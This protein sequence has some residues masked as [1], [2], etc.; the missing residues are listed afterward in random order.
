MANPADSLRQQQVRDTIV[1]RP[2]L[3]NEIADW[4]AARHSPMLVITGR[5][6]MG[7]TV[8]CNQ[9]AHASTKIT[10][11]PLSNT[12]LASYQCDH[13]SVHTHNPF[14]FVD[15]LV[16]QASASR[17]FRT[18]AASLAQETINAS[19]LNIH[20]EA[21]V[22][23]NW[24]TAVGVFIENL[25]V[26][27]A[28]RSLHARFLEP[29]LRAKFPVAP[30]ILI[31]G[32]DESSYWTG[33]DSI[34]RLV[35]SGAF[36]D[37][38]IRLVVTTRAHSGTRTLPEDSLVIDL[39]SRLQESIRDVA[40]FI[41]QRESS[42]EEVSSQVYSTAIATQSGGNFLCA[43]FLMN[44]GG[45]FGGEGQSSS[46]QADLFRV[47]EHLL[48]P[49]VE[50]SNYGLKEQWR[51]LIRPLLGALAVAQ[52]PGLT[53][54]QLSSILGTT[55]TATADAL[56]DV[57]MLVRG[58][59][60][61]ETT[62]WQLC[63]SSLA[64]FLFSRHVA[65]AE[66]AHLSIGQ[67][68]TDNWRH[69]WAQCDDDYASENAVWHL[70]KA[71][72]EATSR[73]IQ[74]MASKSLSNVLSDATFVIR[75]S[76][77]VLHSM[78][79]GKRSPL[80]LSSEAMEMLTLMRRSY[81]LLRD[82]RKSERSAHLALAASQLQFKNLADQFSAL[83]PHNSAYP[84]WTEWIPEPD[85][86]L[87]ARLDAS[88][89]GIFPVRG[90]SL[91]V[92]TSMQVFMLDVE[93]REISKSIELDGFESA[94]AD[95]VEYE[96]MIMVS[97]GTK[98][99]K[100]YLI[101][102]D[103]EQVVYSFRERGDGAVT[104]TTFLE[105]PGQGSALRLVISAEGTTTYAD[106]HEGATHLSTPSGASGTLQLW[107]CLTGCLVNELVAGHEE[108]HYVIDKLTA[109]NS[110]MGLCLS[111]RAFINDEADNL[112]TKMDSER[113][114]RLWNFLTGA[115]RELTLPDE[116]NSR[117]VGLL[118]NQPVDQSPSV[119]LAFDDECGGDDFEPF[120]GIFDI[121]S[122][123][124]QTLG[125]IGDR[126]IA[127][128]VVV[129]F[130]RG[131]GILFL[132]NKGEF[133]IYDLS[134]GSCIAIMR[135][136]DSNVRH[137][138]VVPQLDSYLIFGAT[139]NEIRLWSVPAGYIPPKEVAPDR[140]SARGELCAISER[141]LV[142]GRRDEVLLYDFSTGGSRRLFEQ[143]FS[144]RGLAAEER[145]F[146]TILGIDSFQDMRL[147]DIDTG[148]LT[149]YE[150]NSPFNTYSSTCA[151]LIGSSA[152]Y[153][154]ASSDGDLELDIWQPE[155]GTFRTNHLLKSNRAVTSLST[156]YFGGVI[157]IALATPDG[158]VSVVTLDTEE[159]SMAEI[160]RVPGAGGWLGPGIDIKL[161]KLDREFLLAISRHNSPIELLTLDEG[162]CRSSATIDW[163][164]HPLQICRVNRRPWLLLAQ[165]STVALCDTASGHALQ[166]DVGARIYDGLWVH[167]KVALRTE[168]GIICLRVP[169][170]ASFPWRRDNVLRRRGMMGY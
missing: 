120:M 141:E 8:V 78:L 5:A 35:W 92:V 135:G 67:A 105:E 170:R 26:Q 11:S 34:E 122:G 84:L 109:A 87:L 41:S 59:E 160:H 23:E 106:L 75:A 127:N 30:I 79:A 9:W 133:G 49:W 158:T 61:G 15:S 110:A 89:V 129:S 52:L 29:V 2:W 88:I 25:G 93:S 169:W 124:L 10:K 166:L 14:A 68:L 163:Q 24:G 102:L 70:S 155:D 17:H 36:S 82:E 95:V 118:A 159:G 151:M 45:A 91:V 113:S 148:E 71:A 97:L 125:S 152:L 117:I 90:H 153:L 126:S 86:D 42:G 114:V 37:A 96:N 81:P 143:K 104:A 72:L 22:T 18:A 58:V 57:K 111:D 31:D 13:F 165:G 3:L 1:A 99:G 47:Y 168:R 162:G 44:I 140:Y 50:A 6:G 138:V 101:N 167:D 48:E 27:S 20:G 21:R 108:T 94:N 56:D 156:V 38:G 16:K 131:L 77:A 55:Q 80:N 19:G 132:L 121:A 39:D 154:H 43:K 112:L 66:E 137:A 63:H 60:N 12:L 139:A 46:G 7:K 85:Y 161:A 103:R 142:V 32:L 33:P 40:T 62:R 54:E 98:Q 28:I 100:A 116:I 64:A 147:Y 146:A 65:L 157:W 144:T 164:G 107:D 128:A 74:I 119:L 150:R 53:L 149:V 136:L 76:Q 130:D 134:D 83:V 4:I 73:R 51:T 115:Y 123:K 145:G 69:H